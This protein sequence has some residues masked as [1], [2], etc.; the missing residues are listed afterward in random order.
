M[1]REAEGGRGRQSEAQREAAGRRIGEIRSRRRQSAPFRGRFLL[2]ADEFNPTNW[3]RSDIFS[4][5][6]GIIGPSIG[7]QTAPKHSLQSCIWASQ[8]WTKPLMSLMDF[9]TIGTAR[10]THCL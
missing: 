6:S 4:S 8:T 5:C 10:R 3:R 1:Q 2:L 7:Q 9:N